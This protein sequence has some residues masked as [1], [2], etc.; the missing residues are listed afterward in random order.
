MKTNQIPN[1]E[2]NDIIPIICKLNFIAG[3]KISVFFHGQIMNCEILE[4]I[5]ANKTGCGDYLVR[6][7]GYP[8]DKQVRNL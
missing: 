4:N 1:I 5:R 3:E 6:V 2:I 8:V 7:L